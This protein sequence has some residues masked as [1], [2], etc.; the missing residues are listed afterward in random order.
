MCWEKEFLVDGRTMWEKQFLG[1]IPRY[2]YGQFVRASTKPLGM[3]NLS[4][5][6]AL[7]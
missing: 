3:Q 7:L 5:C 1:A 2:G 6:T 4:G